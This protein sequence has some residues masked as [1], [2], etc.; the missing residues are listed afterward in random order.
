MLI[1]LILSLWCTFYCFSTVVNR[2]PFNHLQLRTSRKAMIDS[3]SQFQELTVLDKE[4]DTVYI[5]GIKFF[6][7]TANVTTVIL[8]NDSIYST[9]FVMF[10]GSPKR[11]KSLTEKLIRELGDPHASD[12]NSHIWLG[13][14]GKIFIG[15]N[16]KSKFI[17]L[18]FSQK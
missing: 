17:T 6:D 3:L 16:P 14:K 7:A 1:G 9:S 5:A 18:L 8:K 4:S 2:N 15:L 13:S 11:L 12:R 10:D